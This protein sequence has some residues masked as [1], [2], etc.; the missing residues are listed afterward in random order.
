MRIDGRKDERTDFSKL[1]LAFRDFA[2][3]CKFILSAPSSFPAVDQCPQIKD[4]TARLKNYETVI[5]R[6]QD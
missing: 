5:D 2:E 1:I 4:R 6:E 3:D